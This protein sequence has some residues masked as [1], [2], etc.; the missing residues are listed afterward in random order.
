MELLNAGIGVI[1]TVNIQ[2][3][4]SIADAV[5]EITNTQ[6]GERVPDWVLRKAD[7]I[8]LVDSSPEQL[9][10]RLLHGNVS[11]A[12]QISQALD[13]FFRRDNLT[14][15]RELALRVLADESDVELLNYLHGTGNPPVAL[16][17]TSASWWR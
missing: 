2:H 4:E 1:T 17:P 12:E 3:L 16:T 6:I 5:E 9:R 10:R 8:E 15:L 14:A 13:K 11:P 7:Q